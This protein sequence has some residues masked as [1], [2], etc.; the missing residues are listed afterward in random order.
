ML[1]IGICDQDQT[2]YTKLLKNQLAQ[3]T[4]MKSVNKEQINNELFSSK[5]IYALVLNKGYTEKMLAGEE[6]SVKSYFLKENDQA[7]LVQQYAENYLQAAREI[8]KIANGDQNDFYNKMDLINNAYLQMDNRPLMDRQKEKA[9]IVL[10][11][12]LQS[13]LMAG[14]L[15]AS[16]IQFDRENKTFYRTLMTP[17]TLR[18][19]TVQNVLSYLI[20]SVIQVSVVFLVLKWL[21]VYMGISP[22]AM[23]LLFLTAS[24]ISVALGT[25]VNSLARSTLQALFAG[26]FIAFFMGLLGG[27]LWE[28]ETATTV[29]NNSGK[30]TPTYW[31]MDGVSKLLDN[32][33]LAAI[34]SNM[35]VVLLFTIV[36][37]F[38][39]SWKKENI[40]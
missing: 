1:S 11:S 13:I 22:A 32:Q 10:G 23:Y 17:V 21:G 12:F 29:L 3:V 5:I 18:S 20:I 2:E 14:V 26:I 7:Q 40:A 6:V 38:L 19:Y 15:I 35:A 16:I 8:A 4:E 33:G 31:I 28:H 37:L 25:A 36:F 30:F 39:G 34:S 9:Y 24:L 27:C